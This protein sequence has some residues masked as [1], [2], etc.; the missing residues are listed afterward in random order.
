[1]PQIFPD[2]EFGTI[3]G[4]ER[5]EVKEV[6]NAWPDVTE[7]DEVVSLVLNNAMN[8]LLGYPHGCEDV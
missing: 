4:I 6:L 1:V 3:F 5:G 8:N 2:W 7:E